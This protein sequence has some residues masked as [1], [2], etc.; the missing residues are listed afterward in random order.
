[1]DHEVDVGGV[2][3]GVGEGGARRSK[4]QVTVVEA[5]VGSAPFA[6]PKS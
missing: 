1:M 5:A 3:P 4:S 6:P 2:D